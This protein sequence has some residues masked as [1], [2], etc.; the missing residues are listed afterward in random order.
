MPTHHIAGAMILLRAA[1]AETNPQIVDTSAG[2][3]PAALLP[4]IGA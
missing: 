3:R 2:L 1:V 4:A